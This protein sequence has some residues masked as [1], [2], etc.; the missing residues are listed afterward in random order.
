G[1]AR[2]QL[3]PDEPDDPGRSALHAVTVGLLHGARAVAGSRTV[4]AAL[5]AIGAH[6]LVFG[7]NTLMLLVIGKQAGAGD[8]LAGVSVVAGFTAGGAL[9]AALVTPYS[10]DRIGRKTTLIVALLVGAV[11]EVSLVT[12]NPVVLCISAFVL[13][14]IGQIAKLCGDV[15]MQ[16]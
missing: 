7:M 14:L 12:F 13:G 8:G 5:S 2:L 9:L 4:S 16:V 15:A 3:G 11:A 10:V 1:F 6:R